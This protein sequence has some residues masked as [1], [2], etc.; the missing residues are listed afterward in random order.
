MRRRWGPTVPTATSGNPVRIPNQNGEALS[1]TPRQQ[2][3]AP[4]SRV[5]AQLGWGPGRLR[6]LAVAASCAGCPK[7]CCPSAY[8]VMIVNNLFLN[9]ADMEAVWVSTGRSCGVLLPAHCTTGAGMKFMAAACCM[10]LTSCMLP[11]LLQSAHFRVDPPAP[12][13]CPHL[14]AI[15][16][17]DNALIIRCGGCSRDKA[18]GRCMSLPGAVA[19]H[20][21]SPATPYLPSLSQRACAPAGRGNLVWSG[22]PDMA[23]LTGLGDSTGCQPSNPTCNLLQLLAQNAIN[24]VQPQLIDP[25]AGNFRQVSLDPAPTAA[26]GCHTAPAQVAVCCCMQACGRLS[27]GLWAALEQPPWVGCLGPRP[28]GAHRHAGQRCPH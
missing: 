5:A 27:C 19:Q 12:S 17:A 6:T 20:A 3:C 22:G 16:N 14:P 25:E 21:M 28:C 7:Q 2:C 23:L 13:L 26:S 11:F 1:S 9:P 10:H 24:T 15:V 4:G 18:L 8:A